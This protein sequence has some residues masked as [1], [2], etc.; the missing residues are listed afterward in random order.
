VRYRYFN[1]GYVTRPKS[2]LSQPQRLFIG[3]Q[4]VE[5]SPRKTFATTNHRPPIPRTQTLRPN[6]A[7]RTVT[8]K[9]PRRSRCPSR[10]HVS[11]ISVP[12][13]IVLRR[14]HSESSAAVISFKRIS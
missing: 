12:A 4:W 6:T 3:G 1:D 2:F 8:G 9:T 11:L 13:P 5:S 14:D 10:S 7:D